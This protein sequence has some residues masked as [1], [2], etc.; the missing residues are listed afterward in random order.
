MS[1]YNLTY[2]PFGDAAILIEWP[3]RIDTEISKDIISFEKSIGTSPQIVD[4]IIGYNSLT[5]RY[6]SPIE[7]VEREMNTLK[8]RYSQRRKKEDTKKRLWKIPVCYDVK[9]GLDLEEMALKKKCAIETIIKRHT[10]SHYRVYFI[11]FQPGFLYLGGLDEYLYMPRKASPRLCV[12]K[13]SVGIGAA[14]TG[15]Y[16]QNS[17][18]GWNIIGKSPVNFFD[19]TKAHPCFAKAG[20]YIQFYSIDIE[21]FYSIENEVIN[22]TYSLKSRQI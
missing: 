6:Y 21:T 18:G 19:T 20:D 5:I 8:T 2:R 13:G 12:A 4:K 10:A 15:I 3:N 17:A 7:N 1:H 9:F 14:Q 22:K 16:P 11:G